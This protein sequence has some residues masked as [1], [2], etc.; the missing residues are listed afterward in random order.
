MISTGRA[1][2]DITVTAASLCGR[3]GRRHHGGAQSADDVTAPKRPTVR[4]YQEHKDII[5]EAIVAGDAATPSV[6]LLDAIEAYGDRH[7]YGGGGD[8]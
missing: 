1:S 5:R 4:I 6:A 7:G 3:Q 2:A 8:A